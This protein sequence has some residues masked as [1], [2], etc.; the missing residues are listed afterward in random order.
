ML[1][2]RYFIK[3]LFR[4][5][6][7]SLQV[8]FY[9]SVNADRLFLIWML[10]SVLGFCRYQFNPTFFQTSVTGQI[11]L[12]ALMNMPHTDFVLCKALIDTVRV[13]FCPVMQWQAAVTYTIIIII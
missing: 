9:V 4:N 1:Q 8:H 10:Q 7:L 2:K 6:Y 11:L 5:V 12:K 13:S 3:H